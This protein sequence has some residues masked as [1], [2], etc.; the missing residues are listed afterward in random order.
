MP[1]HGVPELAD[2]ARQVT[3]L[4]RSAWKE[5]LA[6]A[7]G[8]QTFSRA[9][10]VAKALEVRPKLGW[11]VWR[12]MNA[13]DPFEA[14]DHMPG[15]GSIE[16]VIRAA[17]ERGA[18]TE[19][20]QQLRAALREFGELVRRHAGDRRTLAIMLAQR[21]GASSDEADEEHRRHGFLA[22]S[23]LWGVQARA[24]LMLSIIH[25]GETDDVVDVVAVRG[26]IELRRLRPNHPW[27]IARTGCWPDPGEDRFGPTRAPLYPAPAHLSAPILEEFCSPRGTPVRA[28]PVSPTL[29]DIEL[30][31]APVGDTGLAT[32]LTG[33]VFRRLPK[34][35]SADL[36]R[37]TIAPV[38]LTPCKVF[39]HDILV[40]PG[41]GELGPLRTTVFGDVRGDGF[42][43]L[44]ERN[45]LSVRASM[46]RIDTG[47]GAAAPTPWY[48]RYAELVDHVH[49]LLGWK[50][51]GY[52]TYRLLLRY[53]VMPSQISTEFDLP[54]QPETG[55][56]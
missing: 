55:S 26:V 51:A 48:S 43:E 17:R 10:E 45:V 39:L 33:E 37:A 16:T 14:L 30:P 28:I 18:S 34:Y 7:T 40:H 12:V 3:G 46:R 2:D 32:C 21:P 24:F 35:R 49:A 52:A 6:E 44:D 31:P 11:Q 47:A 19:V 41:A 22:S 56:R 23:Y 36:P 8:G 27:I 5:L 54:E 13:D 29:A 9:T 42:K 20:E 1:R 15:A 53:P 50:A 38:V 25:P 4:L